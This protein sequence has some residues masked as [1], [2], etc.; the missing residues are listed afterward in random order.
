[1]RRKVITFEFMIKMNTKSVKTE[2]NVKSIIIATEVPVFPKYC[3][4]TMRTLLRKIQRGT[5]KLNWVFR[6]P[7]KITKSHQNL[8]VIDIVL[9]S[10]LI[11]K[12]VQN[13]PREMTAIL[14]P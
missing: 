14:V 13:I 7:L 2:E 4:P 10:K 1:M 11:R 5:V 12:N 8:K 6:L 9:V 3:W